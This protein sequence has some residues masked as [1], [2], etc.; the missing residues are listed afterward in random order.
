MQ[1]QSFKPKHMIYLNIQQ[2]FEAKGIENPNHY[3]CKN[4]FTRHTAHNLLNHKTEGINFKHLE[5]LCLL[6]QCAPNDLFCWNNTDNNTNLKHHPLQV[7]KQKENKGN[8]NT[9]LKKLPI[10]KLNEL[11]NFIDHLSKEETE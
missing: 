5:K 6:L 4:G 2:I 1:S 7:I 11:R 9:Q 8:I 10:S 3:L